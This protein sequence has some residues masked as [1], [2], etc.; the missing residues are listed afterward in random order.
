[1]SEQARDQFLQLHGARLRYRD[2]GEGQ[3]IV[4]VHGWTLDL[5]MWDL[6]VARLRNGF[7]LVRLD[8]RG[9]G[10]ST[11]SSATGRDASDLDS[12]CRHLRLENVALIGTSQGARGVLAFAGA[13]P[14]RVRAL[15]LDGVPNL[16]FPTSEDDVPLAHYRSLIHGQGIEAVRREWQRHPLMQLRTQDRPTRELL[17]A[18]LQR[19]SGRDLIGPVNEPGTAA[20]RL[21][22]SSV[23]APTLILNGEFDL[24]SRL[25]AAKYLT[26]YLVGAERSS[27]AGAGHLPSLDNPD[28][29]SELC[30]SFLTRHMHSPAAC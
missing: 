18:M 13:A 12:L 3:A 17:R 27:I 8:R 4:L 26:D 24:A 2:E 7:R 11:G 29:Y 25:T 30:R 10:L 9:H 28:V 22:L 5:A 6:Q 23:R 20:E 21:P 19:Y 16:Q 15:V 1:M 14:T